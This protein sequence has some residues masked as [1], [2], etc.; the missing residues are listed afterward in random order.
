M[1]VKNA[2]LNGDLEEEIYMKQPPGFAAA[3]AE[4]KVCALLKPIYGLK[5]ADRRWYKKLCATFLDMGYTRSSVDHSVFFRYSAND[6]IVIVAVSVDDLAIAANTITAMIQ[7]KDALKARFEMTNLEELHWLLGIEIQHDRGWRTLSMSQSAYIDTIISRFNLQDAKPL[8]TPLDPSFPLSNAQSPS[9]PQQF[10]DMRNVLYREAI[11][12]LM[13]ATLGTHPDVA[14]SVTTFSQFMQNLGRIHWEATKCVMRYLKA[15][16]DEWLIYGTDSEGRIAGYSDADWG[17]NDH[18]HSISG[19]VFLIDGGAVLW[20]AKKQLIVA[21]SSTEAEYVALTHAAKEALWMRAF[22]GEILGPFDKPTTIF[23]DN[24]SAIT[25]AQDNIF[26]SH[27]KHIAIRYHFIRDAVERNEVDLI[28]CPT[29][30]MAADVF[31]KA[32]ACPKM[33]K[34]QGLVGI[35]ALQV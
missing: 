1:D 30:E 14:Y 9:T 25:L 16:R 32:L 22:L 11:G 8:S 34:M 19:Y 7:F 17:S 2:Y 3:G 29:G 13:Y 35:R 31:T 33:E 21:L 4:K 10:E 23:G 28:Y 20:S 6:E 24:Q 15:T 27:T 18:R 5:Q 12:S 26:H